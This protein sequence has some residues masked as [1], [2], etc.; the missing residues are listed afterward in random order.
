MR[1]Q[2]NEPE[3]NAW[4]QIEPVLDL[5]MAQ[6]G[7]TDH[8]AIVLRFFEGKSFGDVSRALGTSED[9][10]KKRVRRAVEKLRAFLTTAAHAFDRSNCRSNFG[11]FRSGCTDWAGG[12]GQSRSGAWNKCSDFDID[13][14][15]NHTENYGMDQT[16][17]RSRRGS[18]CNFG[19][20]HGYRRDPHRARVMRSAKLR[21]SR[22]PDAPLLRRPYSRWS[23][24][25]PKEIWRVLASVTP[26]QMNCGGTG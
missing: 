13:P 9:A 26:E 19:S 15:R 5:A 1:C 8:N 6:L 22:T 14:H 4:M 24:R 17:N 12:F 2:L 21:P 23:R 18:C 11:Q 10:A 7:E 20:R 3:S 16:Q 25:R